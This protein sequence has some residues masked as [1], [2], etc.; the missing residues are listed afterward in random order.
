MV[1]EKSFEGG[2]LSIALNGRLNTNNAPLLEAALKVDGVKDI[3]FDFKELNYISSTGLK[4][5]TSA[6]KAVELSGGNVTIANANDTVRHVFE[7]MGLN[8]MFIFK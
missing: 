2:T 4:V 1:I 8:D 6:Q 7:I 3:N 5:I